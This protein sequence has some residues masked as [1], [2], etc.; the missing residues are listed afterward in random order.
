MESET[1]LIQK[2]QQGNSQA[3][4]QLYERYANRVYRYLIL[5]HNNAA[6]AEDLTAETFIKAFQHIYR[7]HTGHTPFAAWLFRIAHNVLIDQW[8]ASTRRPGV[9][10]EEMETLPD[11]AATRE[12]TLVFTRAELEWGLTQLTDLQCQVILRRFGAD[13]SIAETAYALKRSEASIKDAQH[14][15]LAALRQRLEETV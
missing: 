5:R 14:K 1:T 8:R 12:L 10:W 13:C 9:T 4:G 11:S 15:A 7:Y 6:E 3:F 2:I